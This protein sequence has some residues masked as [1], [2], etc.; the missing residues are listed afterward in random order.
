MID[1]CALETYFSVDSIASSASLC[2][3]T[4]CETF[5]EHDLSNR[6]FA[7]IVNYTKSLCWRYQNIP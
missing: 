2:R 1:H 4:S 6:S 7:W 3:R 5:S